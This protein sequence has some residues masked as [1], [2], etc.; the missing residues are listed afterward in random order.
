MRCP[1]C[2]YISFESGGRCRNCGF[3]FSLAVADAPRPDL[4]IVAADA[5]EGPL[6]DFALQTAR[7]SSPRAPDTGPDLPLFGR[8][9]VDRL[10]IERPVPP[11]APLAV[12]R[13]NPSGRERQKVQPEPRL[14]LGAPDDSALHAAADGADAD[15]SS[16][17]SIARIAA[18]IIDAVV[19]V[20]IDVGVIYL[21]LRLCGLTPAELRVLPAVPLGA[22]LLLLAGGY[23]ICF[24][25]AGGQTIG[26]MATRIRVVPVPERDWGNGRVA[27]GSA[28]L[29]AVGCLVSV[30]TAGLGYL[31][32]LV[33]HDHRAL[34]DRLAD[35]R[36][37]RA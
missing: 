35:T 29:R 31:P 36:V 17:S 2:Q 24:T 15:D 32:A 12:R 8:G 33:S 26:K 1:K 16:A 5:A 22:F 23:I 37:V 9:S 3:D 14:D 10:L 27:L 21:T 20:S 19:I 25:V 30:L 28:V 4:P 6:A 18:A 13:S 11:R 34:H 7:P